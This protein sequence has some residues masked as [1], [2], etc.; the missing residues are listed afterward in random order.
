MSTATK[1]IRRYIDGLDREK[2]FGYVELHRLGTPAQIARVCRRL[3]QDKKIIRLAF[4]LFIKG[5]PDDTLIPDALEIA[6]AKAEINKSFVIGYHHQLWHCNWSR[7]PDH[8][9]HHFLALGYS[10]QFQSVCG[11]IVLHNIRSSKLTLWSH[12][13]IEAARATGS[14][15][16]FLEMTSGKLIGIPVH[17]AVQLYGKDLD[18]NFVPGESQDEED[19]IFWCGSCSDP[20]EHT[21][22]EDEAEFAFDNIDEYDGIDFTPDGAD[23]APAAIEPSPPPVPS[24]QPVPSPEPPS[25]PVKKSGANSDAGPRRSNFY[26]DPDDEEVECTGM[27]GIESKTFLRVY[28]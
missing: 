1:E 20:Y 26:V 12:S 22:P 10:C 8:D 18:Y 14:S 15:K 21:H 2:I 11:R 17:Q 24:P 4:G 19:D 6:C 5:S 3:E 13:Q 28:H 25:I 7:Q 27:C 23:H 9:A 16:T